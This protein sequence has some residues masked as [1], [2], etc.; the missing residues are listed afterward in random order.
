M[1][2]LTFVNINITISAA[3]IASVSSSKS[4]LELMAPSLDLAPPTEEALEHLTEVME[5][6]ELVTEEAGTAHQQKEMSL[7]INEKVWQRLLSECSNTREKAHLNSVN[8][9]HAGDWL[10]VVPS[11]TLGLQL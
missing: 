2:N 1:Y 9:P 4:L 11:P 6:E 5:L 10:Y 8:L 3:Y 7:I